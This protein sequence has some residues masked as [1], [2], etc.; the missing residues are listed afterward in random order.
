MQNIINCTSCFHHKIMFET[1]KKH[2]RAMSFGTTD[3]NMDSFFV[4]NNKSV[5]FLS[6][7]NEILFNMRILK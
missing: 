7:I 1:N 3:K 6:L 4:H 5:L 2:L